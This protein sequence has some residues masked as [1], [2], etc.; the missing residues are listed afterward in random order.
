MESGAGY[1]SQRVGLLPRRRAWKYDGWERGADNFAEDNE[2]RDNEY[3][4][5]VNIELTGRASVRLPRRGSTL[6]A[7]ISGKTNFNGWG[8]YKNPASDTNLMIA[9]IDG[10]LYKI[11]GSGVVTEIDNTKTWN[12]TAKMRGILLH[13]WFYFGN[14][15]DYMSKTNGTTVTRWTAVTKPTLVSLALTGTGSDTAYAYTVTAVTDTGETEAPTELTGMG[16][17]TLSNTNKW[18]LTWTRKTDSNIRGYNIYKTVNDGTLT[19]LTFVDQ[20]A[21]GTNMT[22]IDD[23]SETQSLIHEVPTFNT[24]GG[25]K[26]DLYAKYANTLFLSGNPTEVDTVFYGGTGANWES[27]SPSDNGGWVKPGRGDGERVTAMI[28]FDDFL[29]IFKENSIWK[30]VFGGDGGPT[31]S[32][33][34]P[35]YGT[36]SPDSVWR[37]EK[38]I[39][40]F[41]SDGR[42]RVLGYEPTQLNVIRTTDISNRIQPDL[43][44]LDK[45]NMDDFHAVFF[46]QKYILCNKSEA[47]P[48][49]RRYLAFLGKWTNYVYDRFLVWDAG[50]GK[51]MLFGAES[52]TGKIYQL[53]VDDTYDDNGKSIPSSLRVKRI[54]GG[55]D[56]IL[57]YYY[58]LKIK[59]KNPRGALTLL[60]YKDGS[61]LSTTRSVTFDIGGGIDEYMF[62][63]AMWDEGITIDS[64]SDALFVL[65]KNLEFEAYSIY[66][67]IQVIG[68][69]FN[70]CI[71]QT[72]SG[73]YEVE[74]I[75]YERD[76]TIID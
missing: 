13:D 62:D 75:D 34:I 36:S 17:A 70:H 73:T 56:T 11:T 10:H 5:G 1:Y 33:V 69:E 54:D 39:V 43:D 65:K 3:Y 71:V 57:K 55:E 51:H 68:N 26:A 7:T 40:F 63:E 41:G 29:L 35:Q 2:I 76:E 64:V 14:G 50:T 72:M 31:L 53:L 6:F 8:V 61:T 9:M 46:E 47:Y 38:D 15:V 67:Q 45:T 59:L 4:E 27:L 28:G 58:D 48:Y 30:F 44:V 24:T 66:P 12:S 20:L 42:Y 74:D 23:G 22:Y 25:V 52:G 37:M 49:D 32:A 19:L 16:P 21:A 60:L 18:T